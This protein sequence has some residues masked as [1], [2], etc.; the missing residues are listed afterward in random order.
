[1][2]PELSRVIEEFNHF[3][4]SR[5]DYIDEQ[6][7]DLQIQHHKHSVTFQKKFHLNAKNLYNSIINFG[8]P[9]AIEDP[10]LL[11]L[12]TQDAFDASVIEAM[13]SL[14]STGQTQYQKFNHDV[15][16]TGTKSI[17]D[18]ISK[19]SLNL[20]ST[21][22]KKVTTQ[23]GTKLKT[24]Q[25]NN[26]IFSQM[27]AIL[28]QRDVSLQKMFAHEL[29]FFPPSISTFGEMSLP[30]NKSALIPELV[31]DCHNVSDDPVEYQP[32]SAV[33]MDGGR[34]LYAWPPKPNMTFL[35]YAESL[36]TGPIAIFFQFNQR[37][38]VVFDTYLESSLKTATRLRRGKGQRRRVV[39]ENKCPGQWKQF[40]QDS[41]NKKEITKFL[42]E[43]L[44]SF[45]HPSGRQ[46]FATCEE[47][48]LSNTVMTMVESD[49]EKADTR[50]MLHAQH[51]L[52]QGMN[53]VKIISNDTD[54]V[55]I[56]LGIYHKL[57]AKYHFDDIIIE[58]GMKKDHKTINL[59][60]VAEQL[61][62]SRCQ[63][64]PFFHAFT[65]S[66]TTSS[67]K[68]IGKKKAYEALKAF[69]SADSTLAE[70][71]FQAFQNLQEDDEKFG[72][73][74][75]LVVLMYSKTS[76]LTKVNDLRVEMYF[77]RSQNI[78]LIPPTSNALLMHT[79]RA[80]YQSSV[81]SKC[82]QSQQNR[83]SP[84][85]FGWKLADN[86][87]MKYEPFW[88]TQKEA[89]KECREFVKCSCKSEICTRCKCKAAMLKCTLLCSCKCQDKVTVE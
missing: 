3:Q 51:A 7:D 5:S 17:N 63:A 81:W 37:I 27:A 26:A 48:V 40:L 61:G 54:V 19:N 58:F 64:L 82:L 66:D 15:L 68:G 21:P 76:I 20:M 16:E 77:Q 50:V 1:M 65:G 71:S 9:F 39:P 52:A 85:E 78:E 18:T 41:Q 72:I 69:K 43:R 55:I 60:A 53:R 22:L 14:E 38:D 11:S 36:A 56:A 44:V 31:S 86:P 67:F 4:T 79:K 57:R 42:A 46:M 28:Q 12:T 8:N 87:S 80:I 88:M 24:V 30:S 34:L 29:H 70:M 25:L 74:Q 6:D 75:R 89:S 59:K 73:I 33:I 45:T 13:R 62:E 23:A 32:T 10:R 2:T 84:L 49:H 35:Q 83:P 47:K